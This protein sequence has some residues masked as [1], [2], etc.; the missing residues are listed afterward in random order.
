MVLVFLLSSLFSFSQSPVFKVDFNQ[1]GR[2]ATET[3]EPGYT[4]FEIPASATDVITVALGQNVTATF[5]RMGSNGTRLTSN[6]Y[7]AGVQTP[8]FARLVCDGMVV[9]NGTAGA[10]IEMRISGLPA[11]QHSFLTYHNQVDN[12]ATNTF[13]PMDVYVN[14]VKTISK[15]VPSVRATSTANV[16]TA[17]VTAT[18]V[19]GQDVVILYAADLTTSATNRNIIINGLEINTPNAANQARS[20]QPEH[21]DTHANADNGSITLSWVKAPNAANSDVYYGFD[22]TSVA[23][24]TTSSSL[25]KGRL[26]GTTLVQ[27][28]QYSMQ[29][30]FWRVDQIDA[31]GNITKGD[32][33]Y[34]QPRHL[35]FAEAEGYG[36]FARGGRG[37]KVVYVTNL[38]DS[39]SGSLREAVTNDIGP[40][41]IV[42]A[43]SGIITLQSRLTVGSHNVTIAGQTAP[44]KGICIRSA[45]FGMGGNDVVV[46]HVRVRVGS[47]TTYDGMGLN[48]NNSIMDNCSISWTIDEGFS[49][50]GAKNITLQRTMIAEA[51]N[52]AGHQNY[53]A[54]TAH[55]Y[56]ATIGGA[57]GSFHHNLLAHCEGRNW[58]MGGGLDGNGYYSG[59]LDITNNV[60]YNWGG[61]T[62]DGGANQ[63]NFVNN[64]YKT[65]AA[66]TIFY[67]LTANHEG[68]GLG[69]QQYYFAGNVMPGKFT[70]SNQEAGRRIV[71][72]N[73]AIVNWETW[74]TSPFFPSYVQTQ[75]ATDAY[76]RVLSNVGATQ[77][78]FDTHDQRIITETLNGTYTY[79]GSVSGKPGLPDSQ[80][81]VGGYESYP[82]T[83]RAS[84]WDSDNDGLPNWWE[85]LYGLNTNSGAGDFSDANSDTDLDGYTQLDNY[86][87]W[88]GGPHYFGA[89]ATALN[90]DITALSKGYN[91]SPTFTLS[92][93]TNGTAV[94]STGSGNKTVTFTPTAQ[95]FASFKFTVTDAAG[96]SMQRTVNILANGS[97]TGREETP[98]AIQPAG[99]VFKVWPVPNNGRF[100]V[101]ATGT[102]TDKNMLVKV[103]TL[104]GKQVLT[105]TLQPGVQL[106][107]SVTTKGTYIVQVLTTDKQVLHTEKLITN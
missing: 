35:A 94:L 43:V 13:S 50:R 72:S 107:L 65:G 25:Y 52:V 98:P 5:T 84:N 92:N 105:K 62:T 46:R 32:I 29:T 39:G 102:G 89:P 97:V 54:G 15:L 22:S 8:Y 28:S 40:R 88:M 4:A 71:I 104:D 38:N 30:Y 31:A 3:N 7:K 85:T 67:A 24:A 27:N 47:G 51:L 77:P 75:S 41:T 36:R 16:P 101:L 79:S 103:F 1:T 26:T 90:I 81:D 64:Y 6:W 87:E 9:E 91:S 18:A 2:T 82:T 60:V 19:A 69:T 45:P 99:P 86:L 83:T 106:P 66:S 73:G 78:Q 34:Y 37:G 95:G 55:G 23:N 20:P 57:T 68:T 53:P 56:A 70:E 44:G 11:G 17:Y 63:V 12:P 100:Y 33:W 93:I 14:G 49:S 74:V 76:K 80:N 61:R 42:F 48:G 10:Q 58:S 96:S 21:A 59:Q